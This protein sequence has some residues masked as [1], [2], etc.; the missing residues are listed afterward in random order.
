MITDR[1]IKEIYKK[2]NKEVKNPQD[3][4]L[5]HYIK[6]L[7]PHHHIRIDNNEVNFEDQEEFSPFRR[8]L[9]R[10]LYGI[11]EFDRQIAFVF[12]NHILFLSKDSDDM[13]VHMR[14]FQEKG[15]I[16]KRLFANG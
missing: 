8:F 9:L 1:V 14:P 7:A 5:D 13:R 15:N 2:Y 16:F 3:L 6:M 4:R 11:L 12:R 10:S